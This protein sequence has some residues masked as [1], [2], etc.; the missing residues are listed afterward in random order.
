MSKSGKSKMAIGPDGKPL[1]PATIAKM[2]GLTEEQFRDQIINAASS[3][4]ISKG[5]MAKLKAVGMD[6]SDLKGKAAALSAAEPSS[7]TKA[8]P[9][10]ERVIVH[11]NFLFHFLRRDFSSEET[12]LK[13]RFN[14][15]QP[16]DIIFREINIPEYFSNIKGGSGISG[17]LTTF[18]KYVPTIE[19][20]ANKILS[21]QVISDKSIA[22]FARTW[23]FGVLQVHKKDNKVN[24]IKKVNKIE[25]LTSIGTK[26]IETLTAFHYGIYIGGGE[27]IDFGSATTDSEL[28]RTTIKTFRV[29][30]K[31][32]RIVWHPSLNYD[33]QRERVVTDAKKRLETTKLGYNLYSNNCQ[34]VAFSIVL[35]GSNYCCDDV[36][37]FAAT[38]A[39][40]KESGSGDLS[41]IFAKLLG[42]KKEEEDGDS[43]GSA[44]SV[45]APSSSVPSPSVPSAPSHAPKIITFAS[46]APGPP[47]NM[48]STSSLLD[49]P[50]IQCDD[51]SPAT[52]SQS[53]SVE[54]DGS[55]KVTSAGTETNPFD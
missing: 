19:L 5:Q 36:C 34:T 35:T 20:V 1:N 18:Q 52:Q 46:L 9:D 50:E 12:V 3:G 55:P 45:P 44:S 24:D 16:G 51:D 8:P 15:L 30:R 10:I 11:D 54:K 26:L 4:A 29:G 21:H 25:L 14:E 43:S 6:I 40:G 33:A 42:K 53:T 7:V 23:D 2:A 28:R 22:E 17:L 39:K 27:V 48:A 37:R 49:L 38:A 41:A 47:S 13:E 32:H 31:I